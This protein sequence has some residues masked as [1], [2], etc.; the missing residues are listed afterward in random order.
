[1]PESIAANAKNLRVWQLLQPLLADGHEI[2]LCITDINNSLPTIKENPPGFKYQVVSTS[3]FKWQSRIKNICKRFEP[4]FILAVMWNNGVISL[5]LPYKIPLWVDLFGYIFGEFQV[6]YYRNKIN[7]ISLSSLAFNSRLMQRCDMLS[8]CSQR[9]VYA[10]I[11]ELGMA[12]R[13]NRH[14]L[15]YSFA[16]HI[17]P[18]LASPPYEVPRSKTKPDRIEP[19]QIRLL[20]SGSYNAWTDV[21]VLFEGLVLALQAS[22]SLVFVSTGG[23]TTGVDMISYRRFVDRI[24]VSPL[25]DRFHMLGWVSPE[26]LREEMAM[27]EIGIVVD[28]MHYETILGTRTRLVDMMSRGIPVVTTL[29]CELSYMIRDHHAGV[30]CKSGSAKELSEAILVL[31]RDCQMRSTFS[32]NALNL[33]ETELSIPVTTVALREWAKHPEIATDRIKKNR[34]GL[35][36]SFEMHLRKYFMLALW[37]C[38]GRI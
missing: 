1:M 37:K 9:Q 15:G 21:D 12:G 13:L 18:S 33:M 22:P 26:R 6:S 38:L 5:C 3:D 11:S 14:T 8:T 35:I 10:V 2:Y 34:L 27:A 28:A 17:A 32:Q 31:A 29:G 25:R 24:A 7:K 16:H 23:P 4:D 20:W 19:E 36:S 30:T